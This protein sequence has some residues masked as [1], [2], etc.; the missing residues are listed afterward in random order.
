MPRFYELDDGIFEDGI[1]DRDEDY[2]YNCTVPHFID[3]DGECHVENGCPF[4]LGERE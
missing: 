3:V 2:C 4:R 1:L